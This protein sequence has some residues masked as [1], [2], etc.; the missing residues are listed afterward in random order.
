MT[1]STRNTRVEYLYRDASNYKQYGHEVFAG[2]ITAE[3][4]TSVLA[5]LDEGVHFLAEQVGLPPLYERWSTHYPDDDPWHE[6]V[7]LEVVGDPPTRE[8][9]I[10]AFTARFDGIVWDEPAA[11]RRLE[12]WT[13]RTPPGVP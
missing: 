4:R 7:S 5:A 3:Q 13:R 6:L 11:L 1:P 12:E 2:A 10:A 8:E 9:T